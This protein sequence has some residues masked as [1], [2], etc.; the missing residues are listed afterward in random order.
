MKIDLPSVINPLAK[1]YIALQVI[2]CLIP[3]AAPALVESSLLSVQLAAL[4]LEH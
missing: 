4:L 2:L 1:P 3:A